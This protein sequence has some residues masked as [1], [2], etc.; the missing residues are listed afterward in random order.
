MIVSLAQQAISQEKRIA[1]LENQV[2]KLRL[3]NKELEL[4]IDKL[5]DWLQESCS[6]KGT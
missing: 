4:E 3:R 2:E 5:K 6:C 1:V